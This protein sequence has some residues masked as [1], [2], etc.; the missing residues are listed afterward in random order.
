MG[1]FDPPD[2]KEPT[3]QEMAQAVNRL[4]TQIL[5]G[6]PWDE[7]VESH[8]ADMFSDWE[9]IMQRFYNGDINENTFIVEMKN[10]YIAS[11]MNFAKDE[12]QHNPRKYCN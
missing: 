1:R 5:K 2:E 11:I 8:K 12:V 9:K 4:T 10:S 3:V 7:N 6:K